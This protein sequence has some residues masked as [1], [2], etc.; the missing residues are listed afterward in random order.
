MM[1]ANVGLMLYN[2]EKPK[3][4]YYPIEKLWTSAELRLPSVSG[5]FSLY[6]K[7]KH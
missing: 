6:Y 2:S 4:K 1:S 7:N 5:C 3:I